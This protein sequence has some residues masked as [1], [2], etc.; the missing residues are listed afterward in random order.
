MFYR[1]QAGLPR[2][3]VNSPVFDLDGRFLGIPDLLDEE[4]GLGCE[5]DGQDPCL[6]RQH[7]DDNLREEL[8]EDTN[9]VGCRVD[10]LDPR[11]PAPLRERLRDAWARGQARDRRRDRFTTEIPAWWWRRQ[12]RRPGMQVMTRSRVGSSPQPASRLASAPG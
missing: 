6:R 3:E 4:A 7:Q 2:P 11:Y 12:R 9:L 8:L 1:R 10:S 5:F